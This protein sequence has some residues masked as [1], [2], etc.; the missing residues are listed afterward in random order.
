[1]TVCGPVGD[2]LADVDVV[3]DVIESET[4]VV[5]CVDVVDVDTELE[6]EVVDCVDVADVDI[7]LETEE[8][9]PVLREVE[10]TD[11]VVELVLVGTMAELLSM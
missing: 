4:E 7:E 5:D 8:V 3:E 1:V 10:E 9:A 11:F 2:G 6:T